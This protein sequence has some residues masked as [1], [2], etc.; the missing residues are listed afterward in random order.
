MSQ[1]LKGRSENKTADALRLRAQHSRLHVILPVVYVIRRALHATANFAA[2]TAAAAAAG[3]SLGRTARGMSSAMP[4][5]ATCSGTW[6]GVARWPAAHDTNV[7]NATAEMTRRVGN[8]SHARSAAP[9]CTPLFWMSSCFLPVR[10]YGD[11]FPTMSH[12]SCKP[13]DHVLGRPV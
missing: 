13:R 7:S 11:F 8:R 5:Q 9:P 6:F 2:A 10:Y 3:A 12:A 1:T 4:K